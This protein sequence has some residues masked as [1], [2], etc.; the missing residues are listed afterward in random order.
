MMRRHRFLFLLLVIGIALL[1]AACSG[2]GGMVNSDKGQVRIVMSSAADPLA[3]GHADPG[4]ISSQS[5]STV[6]PL[7]GDR[8]D[9]DD[10]DDGC[11]CNR[12]KAANVT[13]SSVLAR[14]LDGELIDTSMDLPRTLNMLGFA[15]GRVVELP[16]GILPP[17]MYDLI[18]VNMT[19]VEFV[20]QNDLK[21]SIEPPL[22]GWIARL[23]VRPRPFEV[24]EGQTTTVALRFFPHRMFKVKNGKFKFEIKDGFEFHD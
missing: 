1:T 19:K 5:G 15:D 4:S 6:T 22:G 8:D 23:E 20:L 10:Y 11:A 16:I 7:D 9:H 18:L 3:V 21:I 24:I 14:N 12:L 17:A 2:D 13:F